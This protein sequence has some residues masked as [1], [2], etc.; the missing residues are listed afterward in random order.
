MSDFSDEQDAPGVLAL[1][2]AFLRT[3]D[4]SDVL[5][6]RRA[7]V[8]GRLNA[9]LGDPDDERDDPGDGGQPA[10]ETGED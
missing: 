5:D 2:V 9:I 1:R 6:R 4:T 10:G 8:D 7:Y 3:G